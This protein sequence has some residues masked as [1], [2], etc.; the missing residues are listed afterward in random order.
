MSWTDMLFSPYGRIRRRDFWIWMIGKTVGLFLLLV[1]SLLLVPHL[2]IKDH[3]TQ[4]LLGV[5]IMMILWG[6]FVLSNIC[7][8]VKRW[9]DRNRTGWMYLILVIPVI[10]WLWT[11]IECGFVDGT[12]G[13]NRFGKSPKGIGRDPSVFD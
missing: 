5:V 1:A 6:L 8:I 4:S 10:G 7:L 13:R 12:Q 9:H 2:P 11:L 3:D